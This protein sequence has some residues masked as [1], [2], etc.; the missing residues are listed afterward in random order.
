MFR[1][2]K[3]LNCSCMTRCFHHDSIP[4]IKYRRIVINDEQLALQN[5][6]MVKFTNGTTVDLVAVEFAV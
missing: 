6:A 2:G 4:T 5:W 1:Q 3:I